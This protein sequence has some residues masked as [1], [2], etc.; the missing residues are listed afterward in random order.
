VIGELVELSTSE[1]WG[2][3]AEDYIASC[4]LGENLK[5]KK[6]QRK[7]KG[8]K[9]MLRVLYVCKNTKVNGVREGHYFRCT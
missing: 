6:I 3:A 8:K 9:E 7:W 5:G 2:L 4:Y 1:G